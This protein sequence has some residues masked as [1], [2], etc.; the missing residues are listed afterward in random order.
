MYVLNQGLLEM[1]SEEASGLVL[2]LDLAVV[3]VE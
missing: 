2:I 3:D 1:W